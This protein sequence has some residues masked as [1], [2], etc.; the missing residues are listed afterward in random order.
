MTELAAAHAKLQA[1]VTAH[2]P[3]RSPRPVRGP[4]AGGEPASAFITS[5][6]PAFRAEELSYAVSLIARTAGLTAA[7]ERRSWRE[8]WLGRQRTIEEDLDRVRKRL[9]VIEKRRK[10]LSRD[11]ARLEAI[12]S[13]VSRDDHSSNDRPRSSN[14]RTSSILPVR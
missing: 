4:A 7:A 14:E 2:L 6:D 10:R 12:A 13:E 9:I 1:G 11:R 5:L 8:R 3:V